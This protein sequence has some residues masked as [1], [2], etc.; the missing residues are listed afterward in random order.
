[1][2]IIIPLCGKGERFINKGYVNYKPM[3]KI[4][5]KL[6]LD[7]V[8]DNLNVTQDDYIFIIHNNKLKKFTKQNKNIIFIEISYQTEGAAETVKLG[9]NFINANYNIDMKDYEKIA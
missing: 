2:N 6:M 4:Y 7:Y 5:D 9:C 3:I 8:I 1:M